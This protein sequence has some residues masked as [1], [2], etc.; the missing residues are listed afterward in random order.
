MGEKSVENILNGIEKS[1]IKSFE[2]VLFSLGIRF[3]GETV[4]KKLAQTFN[5]VLDIKGGDSKK[6]AD[7][8]SQ[9]IA[10]HNYSAKYY[11]KIL[12]APF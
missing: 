7:L 2:K 3:V 1:K 4:A 12:K 5:I 9:L 11:Q 10:I 6:H 8:K